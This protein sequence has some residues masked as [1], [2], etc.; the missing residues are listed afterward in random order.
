M[1]TVTVWPVDAGVTA[2]VTMPPRPAG[3]AAAGVR[4]GTRTDLDS[5]R[6][7]AAGHGS[8]RGLED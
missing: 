3:A 5:F 7:E 2:T 6:H 8:R 4:V 1:M